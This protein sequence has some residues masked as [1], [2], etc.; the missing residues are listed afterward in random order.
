MTRIR[1]V[2]GA[3]KANAIR[4]SALLSVAYVSRMACVTEGVVKRYE[5]GTLES[6][7]PNGASSSSLIKRLDIFYDWMGRIPTGG[8]LSNWTEKT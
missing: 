1:T 3:S 8:E 5:D 4:C 7:K 2:N 6:S